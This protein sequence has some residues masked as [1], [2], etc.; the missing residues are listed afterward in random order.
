MVT[1]QTIEINGAGKYHVVNILGPT[2]FTARN[3]NGNG[4]VY[5][6]AKYFQPGVGML[7]CVASGVSVTGGKWVCILPPTELAFGGGF[8]WGHGF[9]VENLTMTGSK[10]VGGFNNSSKR[11]AGVMMHWPGENAGVFNC[12]LTD[13]NDFGEMVSG[14]PAPYRA[15][16]NSHFHN[17]VAGIGVR[18]CSRADMELSHSGDYNPYALYV[19]RQGEL[20]QSP[21]GQI[22][23]PTYQDLN[24]GGAITLIAPKIESFACRSGYNSYSACTPDVPGKGQMM[25][26]LTGRFRLTVIGGSSFVHGGKVDTL[27][28]IVDDYFENG[29]TL[30]L[31]NS[32][33]EIIGHAPV[34]FAHWFHIVHQNKKFICREADDDQHN[35]HVRWVNNQNGGVPWN[36]GYTNTALTTVPASYK[37]VQPFKNNAN[38]GTWNHNA[39][40]NFGYNTVTG[41]NY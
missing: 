5:Q 34:S 24:A 33:V 29:G 13:Y 1:N 18:G 11:S 2:T 25:A 35:D 23:W 22:F 19:F 7:N 36:V 20:I 27:I 14:A 10:P 16:D 9:R 38:P 31:D 41:V 30:P 37:G 40:P 26:R 4:A 17:G 21:N 15:R 6:N 32:S 39:A 28:R 3:E 12:L 8:E